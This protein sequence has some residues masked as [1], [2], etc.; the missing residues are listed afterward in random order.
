[1]CCVGVGDVGFEGSADAGLDAVDGE[2]ASS[3]G[4]HTRQRGAGHQRLRHSESHRRSTSK[5]LHESAGGQHRQR[6]SNVTLS[7]HALSGVETVGSG[8]IMNRCPELLGAP[9][10]GA[11]KFYA[12][13]EYATCEKLSS[14]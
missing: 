3:T 9:E 13:K 10:S 6:T 4:K 1:M 8:G 7:S 12:R 14:K 2:T 11:K 5:T